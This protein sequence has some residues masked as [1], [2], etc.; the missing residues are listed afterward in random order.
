MKKAKIM[1]AAIAAVGIAGGFLAFKT[2]KIPVT[3]YTGELGSGICTVATVGIIQH[4]GTPMAAS[5]Q[6]LTT[7]CPDVHTIRFE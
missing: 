4:A 6:P 1:L 3:I 5:T 2:A 7:G